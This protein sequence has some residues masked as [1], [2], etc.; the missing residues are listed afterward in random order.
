MSLKTTKA[1]EALIKFGLTSGEMKELSKVLYSYS[2]TLDQQDG[3]A[4]F[5][6]GQTVRWSASRRGPMLMIGII[7]KVN[8]TACKV[9]ASP[10]CGGRVWNI[11]FTLLEVVND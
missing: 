1:F 5:R 11:D 3:L 10:A 7:Q 8:V 6:A 2:R 4:K 9:Q